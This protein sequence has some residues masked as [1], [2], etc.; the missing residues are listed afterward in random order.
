MMSSKK[1]PVLL[2]RVGSCQEENAL[3]SR[4]FAPPDAIKGSAV[5]SWYLF[6]GPNFELAASLFA[7]V[8]NFE[9]ELGTGPVASIQSL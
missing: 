6:Q 4:M 5:P 9:E 8:L 2:M 7:D 1:E 3:V